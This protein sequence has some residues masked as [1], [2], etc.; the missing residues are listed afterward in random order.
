MKKKS[1][2][3]WASPQSST[4]CFQPVFLLLAGESGTGCLHTAALQCKHASVSALVLRKGFLRPTSP[5][6]PPH[7]SGVY[8]P[9]ASTPSTLLLFFRLLQS[10]SNTTA[11]FLSAPCTFNLWRVFSVC[12]RCSDLPTPFMPKAPRGE[13]AQGVALSNLMWD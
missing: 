4:T 8:T 12:R 2:T 3:T 11:C 9:P 13:C 10:C 5:P 1:T 6:P 7:L